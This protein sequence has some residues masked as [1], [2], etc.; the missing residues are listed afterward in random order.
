MLS[1]LQMND[2]LSQAELSQQCLLF[3]IIIYIVHNLLTDAWQIQE[4]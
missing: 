4:V 1:S 2:V 3:F